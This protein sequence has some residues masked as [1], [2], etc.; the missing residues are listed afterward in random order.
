MI[1]IFK[2]VHF[3]SFIVVR[4]G[5]ALISVGTRLKYEWAASKLL[6]YPAYFKRGEGRT[7]LKVFNSH[8]SLKI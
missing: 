4:S 1:F 5:T 8:Y 2:N 6:F 7:H 3:R